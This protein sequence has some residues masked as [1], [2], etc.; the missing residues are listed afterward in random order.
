MPNL[1]LYRVIG[2]AACAVGICFLFAACVYYYCYG[3][4]EGR[5]ARGRNSSKSKQGHSSSYS[6][7]RNQEKNTTL[8]TPTSP[9]GPRTQH[10]RRS[11]S[12]SPNTPDTPQSHH[13]NE[14][15][16][17]HAHRKSH[18]EHQRPANTKTEHQTEQAQSTDKEGMTVITIT[19][20]ANE[21][22][23]NGQLQPTTELQQC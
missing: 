12:H 11:G 18:S 16:S 17:R 2:P 15:I 23:V 14:C 19:P 13:S 7:I 21:S 4:N 8:S 20:P 1:K 22:S 3:L 9:E 10:R 6:S 5:P